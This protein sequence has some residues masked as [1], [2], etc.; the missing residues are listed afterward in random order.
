MK[1]YSHTAFLTGLCPDH[2]VIY[3]YSG[4]HYLQE[5]YLK[6]NVGDS[7]GDDLEFVPFDSKELSP[8]DLPAEAEA[9][10]TGEDGLVM[11]DGT[12]PT[13]Q[14]DE[15]EGV[16]ANL[17]L[18][19]YTEEPD[20]MFEPAGEP[21]E[22]LD[23]ELE[24]SLPSGDLMAPVEPPGPPSTAVTE[25]APPTSAPAA[26]PHTRLP[27]A[28][29]QSHERAPRPRRE[30][31]RR[32]KRNRRF[33]T[34]RLHPVASRM[35]LYWGVAGVATLAMLGLVWWLFGMPGYR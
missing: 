32:R 18:L 31:E 34:A 26:E 15:T 23:E 4:F 30:S 22:E 11:L 35:R 9:N 33:G 21:K 29:A 27:A 1:Q 28:A 10:S 6:V 3:L 20:T 13:P 12:A 25:S 14:T 16:R 7:S 2:E 19:E 8:D 17:D 24:L 5:E